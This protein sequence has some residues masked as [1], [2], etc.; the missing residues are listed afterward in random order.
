[1]ML[2]RVAFTSP[3]WSLYDLFVSLFRKGA[4][5]ELRGLIRKKTLSKEVMLFDSG[6]SAIY[7]ALKTLKLKEGNLVAVP[8][9]ICRAVPRAIVAAGCIPFFI[10]IDDEYGVDYNSLKKAIKTRKIKAA[11]IVYQYGKVPSNTK[12]IIS[13]CR[14]NNIKV[15][16][17][18]AVTGLYETSFGLTGT[19][20]DVS[21]IS[22]NIGKLITG[23]GGGAL[24]LNDP[25]LVSRDIIVNTSIQPM[26][27]KLNTIVYFLF[28][29]KY[30]KMLFPFYY[31]LKK[32]RGAELKGDSDLCRFDEGLS[33]TVTPYGIANFQ[34]HC[35]YVV[36]NKQKQILNDCKITA[37]AYTI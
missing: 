36:M 8:S 14:Q 2:I 33:E 29:I 26:L 32:I 22:F 34:A 11:I 18:A 20:G 15:I 5:E 4:T 3:Y 30:K 19:L 37:E 27:K 17:D 16:E 24:I 7:A 28:R 35:A 31:M 6:T 25:K 12:K 1:M 13:L 21:I 23:L 10:D 9:F